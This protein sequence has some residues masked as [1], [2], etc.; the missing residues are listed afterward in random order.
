[1]SKS[2][3]I[4]TF[5]NLVLYKKGKDLTT[6]QLEELY[7]SPWFI[8]TW[9]S[10]YNEDLLDFVNETANRDAVVL[11]NKQMIYDY[12][13]NMIPKLKFKKFEYPKAPKVEETEEKN[14]ILEEDLKYY[15]ERLE[16]SEK[17]VKYL[18]ERD[19]LKI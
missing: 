4:F 1:M 14:E 3:T 2:P 18:V 5:L 19:V 8:N 11:K 6:E 17:E 12:Y 9:I 15:A 10:A 13:K 7:L 16:I